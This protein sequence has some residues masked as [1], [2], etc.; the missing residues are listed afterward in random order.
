M[1]F[2]ATEIGALNFRGTTMQFKWQKSASLWGSVG[3]RA[4][5]DYLCGFKMAHEWH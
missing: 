4:R 3:R 2:N 5:I 1:H